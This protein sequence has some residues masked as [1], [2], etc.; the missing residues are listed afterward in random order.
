[1]HPPADR[2]QL[3]NDADCRGDLISASFKDGLLSIEV[4][5]IPKEKLETGI[6]IQ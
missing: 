3:P 1:M 6:N 2:D 5:K 4:P